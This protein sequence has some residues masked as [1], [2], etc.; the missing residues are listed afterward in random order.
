LIK[1]EQRRLE[2][3]YLNDMPKNI[4]EYNNKVILHNNDVNQ[5]YN[6]NSN[7]ISAYAPEN[8]DIYFIVK[9]DN[10]AE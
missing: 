3:E 1:E 5:E 9:V 10:L 4:A 7:E 8:R 2:T 6:K